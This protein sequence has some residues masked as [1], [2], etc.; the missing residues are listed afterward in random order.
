MNVC[1]PGSN[2][3]RCRSTPLVWLTDMNNLLPTVLPGMS[4]IA[5]AKPVVEDDALLSHEPTFSPLLAKIVSVTT[6]RP[7]VTLPPE[8]M[9]MDCTC[10][11]SHL[12]ASGRVSCIGS[13]MWGSEVMPNSGAIDPTDG[14]PHSTSTP[15]LILIPLSESVAGSSN[16]TLT[17]VRWTLLVDSFHWSGT[18]RMLIAMP[19]VS[20]L[21][22][23]ESPVFDDTEP[24][25]PGLTVETSVQLPQ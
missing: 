18:M 24:T 16:L 1:L 23:M 6:P 7:C 17:S 14:N 25:T 10:S 11:V 8:P 5:S 4:C 21:T 19:D 3:H 12:V 20:G 2:D 13:L 9:L 15:V 22:G